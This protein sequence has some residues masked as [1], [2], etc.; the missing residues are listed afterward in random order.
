M[1]EHYCEKE[2]QV[3]A[4]LRANSHDVEILKHAR[5]CPICSE[6]LLVTECLRE[7][8]EFAPH[9]LSGLPDAAVIW[10]KAQAAAR[11][12]ALARATL[13]IRIARICTLVVV[14]FAAPWVIVESSPLWT[15]TLGS[16]NWHWPS[17]LNETALLLI[18]T[19]TVLCIGLSSW[20]MLREE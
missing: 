13:P 19:G 8:T 17:A 1:K 2:Q 6:V 3:V 11:E 20:Y 16:V 15:E 4:A 12:K 5:N 7:D 10:R 9:E 18:V 14:V